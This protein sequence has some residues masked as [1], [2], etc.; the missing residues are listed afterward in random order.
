MRA[1]FHRGRGIKRYTNRPDNGNP[2][3]R[4]DP[5]INQVSQI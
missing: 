5:P 1:T 4:S 2:G 3:G